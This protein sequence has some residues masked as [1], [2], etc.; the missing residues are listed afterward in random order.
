MCVACR[1]WVGNEKPGALAHPGRNIGAGA[2]KTQRRPLPQVFEIE[3]ASH[4]D[5]ATWLPP[6]QG[7]GHEKPGGSGSGRASSSRLATLLDSIC[8]SRVSGQY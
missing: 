2:R 3:N 6:H 5:E 4:G 7:H 1:I 8:D